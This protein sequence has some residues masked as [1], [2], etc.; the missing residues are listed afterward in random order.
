[1]RNQYGLRQ[2]S[3]IFVTSEDASTNRGADFR[4]FSV[5]SFCSLS[6]SSVVKLE[7]FQFAV[8]MLA[9][10]GT[11]SARQAQEKF[12]IFY[13]SVTC[14]RGMVTWPGLVP[15]SRFPGPCPDIP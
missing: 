10:A 8:E 2:S 12:R 3:E 6:G 15:R 5:F 11:T 9:G 13:V 14:G 7:C 1:M 4:M